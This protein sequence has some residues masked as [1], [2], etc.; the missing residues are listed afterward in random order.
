MECSR[1][2]SQNIKTFEMAHASYNVG[3]GSWNRFL[4]LSVFGPPGL[5]IKPTQNSVVR[6]TSPPGKPI[7]ALALVSVFVF[8]STLIWLLVAY[9]RDGFEDTETQ[10]AL[11]I[12]VIVFIV[13][14]IIVI[15]D[16]IRSVKARKNY[17]EKL[18][19]WV[20]SWICLQ[21]GTIYKLPDLPAGTSR[22]HQIST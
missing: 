19:D 16:I 7:P 11:V 15:W 3:I 12:N 9:R 14:S 10:T 8:F 20:H 13:T 17:P 22:A 1:C 21:C 6:K 2:G 18:D 4:R 5:F